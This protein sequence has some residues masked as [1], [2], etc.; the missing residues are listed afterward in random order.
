MA[1][2]RRLAAGQPAALLFHGLISAAVGVMQINAVV[3]GGIAPGDKVP[4]TVQAGAAESQT[5]VTVAV[6]RN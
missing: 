1:P 4:V 2:V 6:R 5:G 3:P